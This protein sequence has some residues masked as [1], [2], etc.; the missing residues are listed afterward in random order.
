MS[1]VEMR[2]NG[3]NVVEKKNILDYIT[4]DFTVLQIIEML[5]D[6]KEAVKVAKLCGLSVTE[7]ADKL[8]ND[9]GF[10]LKGEPLFQED[11]M[12]AKFYTEITPELMKTIKNDIKKGY[13]S[14]VIVEMYHLNKKE[15]FGILLDLKRQI[16]EDSKKLHPL[17]NLKG[18]SD[19]YNTMFTLTRED[20]E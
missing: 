3:G 13:D 17:N 10:N 18:K 6:D 7:L 12:N 19:K 9:Y 11:S 8:K 20:M 15:A 2:R 4:P 16:L 14:D 5:R 1:V